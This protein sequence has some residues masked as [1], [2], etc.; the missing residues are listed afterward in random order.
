MTAADLASHFPLTDSDSFLDITP[1]SPL[2]TQWIQ[3]LGAYQYHKK[4]KYFLYR[5]I[6]KNY[7]NI[8]S[9]I[10]I[11]FSVLFIKNYIQV[12]RFKIVDLNHGRLHCHGFFYNIFFKTLD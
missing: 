9:A 6:K 4:A 5:A 7:K 2:L 3:N 8:H 11:R 1:S 12:I 10:L